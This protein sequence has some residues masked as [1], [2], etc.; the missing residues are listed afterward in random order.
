MIMAL[1]S[2]TVYH[3]NY[4]NKSCKSIILRLF[5]AL[6]AITITPKGAGLI[7]PGN[8]VPTLYTQTQ[9]AKIYYFISYH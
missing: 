5:T 3:Y 6:Q 2:L 9:G 7:L 8:F 1:G 4:I